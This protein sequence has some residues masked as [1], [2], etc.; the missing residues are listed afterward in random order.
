MSD[1]NVFE[2]YQHLR[3]AR[4]STFD[5]ILRVGG[6]FAGLYRCTVG[7]DGGSNAREIEITGALLRGQLN[8]FEITS[9]HIILITI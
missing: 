1:G 6:A 2:S 8:V 4:T 7:N 3:D 5:N 9:N